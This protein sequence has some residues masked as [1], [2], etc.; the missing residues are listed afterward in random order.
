MI[1][2]LSMM[3]KI[4]RKSHQVIAGCKISSVS[5]KK[6]LFSTWTREGM[7]Y[8]DDVS[9]LF[10]FFWQFSWFQHLLS[11]YYVPGTVHT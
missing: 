2:G 4:L 6:I 7:L 11:T 8:N 10:V 5:I 3:P 9:F 1:I